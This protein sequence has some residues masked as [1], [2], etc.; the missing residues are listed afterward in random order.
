MLEHARGKGLY[1]TLTEARLPAALYDDQMLWRLILAADV[2]CYFG[3]L[4]EMLRAVFDRLRPGGRFIFSLE[5]LLPHHDGDVAG[6]GDWA[7]G[8]L[9]R[10]SHSVRYVTATTAAHGFR[11]LTLDHET[12][13]YEAG[14]PVAGLLVVLE[15]P[16]DDA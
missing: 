16:R 6:T 1:S 11:C 14:G 9:G 12:L 2:L 7:P 10:H 3:A 15:R 5:E 13:R 8:P 4:H